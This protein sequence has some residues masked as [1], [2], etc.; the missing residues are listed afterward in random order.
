MSRPVG[1]LAEHQHVLVVAGV[2]DDV[3]QLL[4]GRVGA[5]YGVE[6]GQVR[7]EGAALG[8]GARPV[9]DADLV[10]LRVEVLLAARP[11]RD[12]LVELVA[13]VHA[14][15]RRAGGREHRADLERGRPAVLQV[16]VED[17]GGV[18]E[19]VR[20]HQVVGLR[21]HLAEVLLDLPLGGAPGEVGVAL[22]E[23]DRAEGLHHRRPRERLGQ[24]DHV[25]VG[26][27]DLPQQ[28]LPE[29]HRLG[30]GV[31]DPEDPHAVGHPVP[32]DAEHLPADALRV[33]VEV[34]RVDVLVLLRRVLRVGDG[35]VGLGREPLGVAG[36]PGVVGRALQ[37]QVEGDLEPDRGGLRHERVEVGER[38]EVGVDRVVPAVLAADR[39]G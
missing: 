38:A 16:G 27:A 13:G 36:H 2:D 23:A 37:G 17:V 10:L 6:L 7:R 24:E 3:A 18:D 4:Q 14:P 34:Q 20:P 26:T 29:R 1:L 15:A 22:L 9:A 12:V 32:H 11:H 5:A 30:V 39:P 8:L 33:V 35:A 21:R 31:V 19:E 25:G 28:P